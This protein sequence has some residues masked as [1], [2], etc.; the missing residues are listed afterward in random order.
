MSFDLQ[1]SG[2]LFNGTC[3]PLNTGRVVLS[4]RIGTNIQWKVIEEYS[5]EGK[6]CHEVKYIN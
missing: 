1:I 2:T 6:H 5:S 3:S 4:Y